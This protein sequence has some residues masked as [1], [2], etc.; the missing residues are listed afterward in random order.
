MGRGG[1]DY[2]AA[3][4]AE[5]IKAHMLY[6]WTDVTGIYQADP[7]LVPKS[8][9]IERIN[10][11]EAI[12]LASF[13]AKVLHPDTLF[14]VLRSNTKVFVGSTFCPEKGGTY[15][16]NGK[17]DKRSMIKAITERGKQTLINVKSLNQNVAGLIDQVFLVLKKYDVKVDIV[18]LTKII[19]S[20]VITQPDSVIEKLILKDLAQLKEVEITLEH[21]LFLTTVVG[22][23]LDKIPRLLSNILDRLGSLNVKLSGYGATGKSLYLLS[24]NDNFLEKVYK[25]LF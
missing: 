14:P 6:I 20:F 8:Q 12:E 22:N 5:A 3:L 25:E 11:E 23:S 21:N 7:K 10:F 4:V 16:D 2:S 18:N 1:S 9:I 13:G 19:F 24:D 17:S 15:I